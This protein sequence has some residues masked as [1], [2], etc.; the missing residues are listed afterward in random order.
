MPRGA[1][2]SAPSL[3]RN[4]PDDAVNGASCLEQ[5][6]RFPIRRVLFSS[7]RIAPLDIQ[8][9]CIRILTKST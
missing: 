4:P 9:A 2:M 1:G 6:G 3:V 8:S 7:Q 5:S